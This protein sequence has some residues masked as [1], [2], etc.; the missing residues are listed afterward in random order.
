MPVVASSRYSFDPEK[1]DVVADPFSPAKQLVRTP[2][3]SFRLKKGVTL[4]PPP[5]ET[6]KQQVNNIKTVL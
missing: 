5:G 3:G 6:E 1:L 4:I 2:P